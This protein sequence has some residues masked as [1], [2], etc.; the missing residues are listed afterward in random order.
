MNT[1]K[2]P[3][4]TPGLSGKVMPTLTPDPSDSNPG[5]PLP[6]DWDAIRQHLN[7]L[8]RGRDER[9]ILTAFPPQL[10][11]G[12][13]RFSR[14][15]EAFP[16]EGFWPEN[17]VNTKMGCLTKEGYGLGLVVNRPYP[18]PDNWGSLPAHRSKSGKTVRTHGASS[19]HIRDCIALFAEGDGGL[20]HERQLAA[21]AATGLT[22]TFV[23]DT[24]GKSLHFIT[25]LTEPLHYVDWILAIKRLRKLLN[26][27]EPDAKWDESLAKPAQVLRLAGSIHPRSG[28]HCRILQGVGTG[29]PQ[30]W[31]D[32]DQRLPQ[33]PKVKRTHKSILGEPNL[34][35]QGFGWFTKQDETDQ[36]KGLVE[37]L[38]CIPPRQKPSDLGGAGGRARAIK[39]LCALKHFLDGDEELMEYVLD[40]AGWFNEW[41][42]PMDE[43][44]RIGDAIHPSTIGV[45]ISLAREHGW[46]HPYDNQRLMRRRR[47]SRS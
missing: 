23:V 27:K 37:M 34:Q 41:W 32:I 42:D 5:K 26:E 38:R 7:F 14:Y 15:W 4:V 28:K 17:S 20:S 24:T 46:L 2:D 10:S 30:R 18:K 21:Y 44:A 45:I 33:L 12:V 39:V 3:V 47:W 31:E 11:D 8:G 40:Q 22:P 9:V 1:K 6:L 43:A 29:K 36:V 13:K 35:D 19:D 16:K 25:V